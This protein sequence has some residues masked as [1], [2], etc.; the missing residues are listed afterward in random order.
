MHVQKHLCLLYSQHTHLFYY[1]TFNFPVAFMVSETQEALG[2][3]RK[4]AD[5]S[6]GVNT[7]NDSGALVQL[8]SVEFFLG[9]SFG[10][11]GE[12]NV[13]A[14][15]PGQRGLRRQLV[16]SNRALLWASSPRVFICWEKNFFF[17][18]VNLT[19]QVLSKKKASPHFLHHCFFQIACSNLSVKPIFSFHRPR[20]LLCPLTMTPWFWESGSCLLCHLYNYQDHRVPFNG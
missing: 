19:A 4:K 8:R 2:V 5:N 13:P 10:R 18:L 7:E 1:C 16:K 15:L 9:L 14:E 17:S 3:F 20:Q 11:Q 12:G 6:S